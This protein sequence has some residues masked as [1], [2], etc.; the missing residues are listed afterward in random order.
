[1]TEQP[2]STLEIDSP[3]AFITEMPELGTA[4]SRSTLTKLSISPQRLP[5]KLGIVGEIDVINGMLERMWAK[6][7]RINPESPRTKQALSNLGIV[8]EECCVKKFNEFKAHT[9][10]EKMQKVLYIYYI[11]NVNDTISQVLKERDRIRRKRERRSSLEVCNIGSHQV[12]KIAPAT[13]T[14]RTPFVNMDFETKI[15]RLDANKQNTM[16]YIEKQAMNFLESER[17]YQK[18]LEK[19]NFKQERAERNK[20]MRD[21]KKLKEIEERKQKYGETLEAAQKLFTVKEENRETSNP[22]ASTTKDYKDTFQSDKLK[23]IAGHRQ[24]E[25]KALEERKKIETRMGQREQ[26]EMFK[27]TSSLGQFLRKDMQSQMVLEREQAKKMSMTDQWNNKYVRTREHV[28]S[29]TFVDDP[30]LYARYGEKMRRFQ[31]DIEKIEKERTKKI[32]EKKAIKEEQKQKVDENLQLIQKDS[33]LREEFLEE[34]MVSQTER[35]EKFYTARQHSWGQKVDLSKFKNQRSQIHFDKIRA[36]ENRKCNIIMAKHKTF[37]EAFEQKQKEKEMLRTTCM[38]N[39]W[40]VQAEKDSLN[41]YLDQ[42]NKIH[43]RTDLIAGRLRKVN[44][45]FN[46]QNMANYISK[47]FNTVSPQ[48]HGENQK[49]N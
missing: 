37:K 19:I 17:D 32:Q 9:K 15:E 24:K 2:K 35:L 3:G 29:A 1:M 26:E 23:R 43:A 10:D 30:E 25:L 13:T 46:V 21:G 22:H 33:N 8:K 49:E 42:V 41:Y 45:T 39:H 28:R 36:N 27:S 11:G 4:R 12:P 6:M 31:N 38:Q 44:T 7:K 5:T 14:A 16:D 18:K 34:K 20:K 40:N 47:N 48:H